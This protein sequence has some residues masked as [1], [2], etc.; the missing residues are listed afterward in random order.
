MGTCHFEERENRA[1]MQ[2][3]SECHFHQPKYIALIID[4]LMELYF[5]IFITIQ[6]YSSCES[7]T[8]VKWTLCTR[9]TELDTNVDLTITG[10]YA[11]LNGLIA[12]FGKNILSLSYQAVKFMLLILTKYSTKGD[13]FEKYKYGEIKKSKSSIV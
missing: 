13:F 11:N 8:E 12:D 10:E 9:K 1:L 5:F 6:N 4:P 7:T 2:F 3:Q